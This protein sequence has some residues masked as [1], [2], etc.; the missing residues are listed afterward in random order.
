[1]KTEIDSSYKVYELFIEI[2]IPWRH[3]IPKT[4]VTVVNDLI[5]PKGPKPNYCSFP[6]V[7]DRFLS[8]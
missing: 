1:M 2:I 3:V 5:F 6:L 8:V 7:L 4:A